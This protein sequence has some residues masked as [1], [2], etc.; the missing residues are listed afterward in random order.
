MPHNSNHYQRFPE[1]LSRQQRLNNFRQI[2]ITIKTRINYRV[3]QK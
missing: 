1:G 3:V 2:K